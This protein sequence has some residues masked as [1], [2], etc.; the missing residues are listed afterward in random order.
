MELLLLGIIIGQLLHK[1]KSRGNSDL[2]G[3]SG[4][5]STTDSTRQHAAHMA[6]TTLPQTQ[7]P[8]PPGKPSRCA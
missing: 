4:S 7:T 2:L 5:L 1:A 6:C 3:A 8:G